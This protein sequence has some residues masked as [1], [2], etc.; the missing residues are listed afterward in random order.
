[1]IEITRWAEAVKPDYLLLTMAEPEPGY[2][3]TRAAIEVFG[4]DVLPAFRH[5]VID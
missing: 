1:V 4:R 5:T 3:S 2:A